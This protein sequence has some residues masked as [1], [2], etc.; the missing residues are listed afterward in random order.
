MNKFAM[1]MLLGA[2][3]AASACTHFLAVKQSSDRTYV[4]TNMKA[5]AVTAV[6]AINASNLAV[7][8]S[9]TPVS[10]MVVISAKGAKNPLLQIEAPT[11]T[12]TLSELDRTRIHVEAAA[13]LPGQSADFGLTETMV[14]N[15]FKAMDARLEAA[16]QAPHQP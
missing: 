16:G 1:A 15:V 14:T 8:S 2:A 9:H 6:Q 13:L 12:L 3:M 11:L 5:V 7:Q 10:G 4:H